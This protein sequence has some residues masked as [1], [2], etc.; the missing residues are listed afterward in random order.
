MSVSEIVDYMVNHRKHL[1]EFGVRFLGDDDATNDEQE[2]P[3]G[4]EQ[5]SD[6]ESVSLGYGVGFGVKCTIYHNFLSNRP[7]AELRAFLKNRRIPR[8]TKFAKELVRVFTDTQE[9]PT[10]EA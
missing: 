8:H 7:A 4:E 1:I 2:Y 9:A 3:E 5:D 6:G 10:G